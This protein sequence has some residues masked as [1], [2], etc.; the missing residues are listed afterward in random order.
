MPEQRVLPWAEGC[1]KG[2]LKGGGK[3]KQQAIL[4]VGRRLAGQGGKGAGRKMTQAAEQAPSLRACLNHPPFLSA[5]APTLPAG[6]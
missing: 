4:E 2:H 1:A 3:Q 5:P 6:L